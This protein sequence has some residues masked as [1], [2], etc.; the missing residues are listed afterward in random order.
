MFST[1]IFHSK[2]LN[3]YYSLKKCLKNCFQ[4]KKTL[5]LPLVLIMYQFV[6]ILKINHHE[7]RIF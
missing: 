1:A 4:Q 7:T 6:F 3:L 2:E 5:Y